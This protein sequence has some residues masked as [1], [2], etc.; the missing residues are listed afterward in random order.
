METRDSNCPSCASAEKV[1]G[2]KLISS[3]KQPPFPKYIPMIK[4]ICAGCG[5]YIKFAIQTHELVETF[6]Q[7]L[8]EKLV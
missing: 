4:E 5:R 6:N 3:G 1:Y 2:L 7:F 8:K